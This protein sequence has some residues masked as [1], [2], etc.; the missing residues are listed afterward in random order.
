VSLSH[1]IPGYL[2]LFVA[3][4]V[5]TQPWRWLGVF[6]S[7]DMRPDSEL[8]KW[9]R[10]VSSALIAGL[11]A[12]MIVFP[13]GALVFVPLWLRIGAFAFG[14]AVL[15]LTRRNMGVGILA[16]VGALVIGQYVLQGLG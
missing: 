1:G 4:F 15:L 3:G 6:L 8:L 2:F 11:V 10:A 16:G 12:R 5:A 13:A 7:K 14:I 9:V